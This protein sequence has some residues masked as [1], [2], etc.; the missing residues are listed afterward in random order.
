MSVTRIGSG[1]KGDP[2]RWWWGTVVPGVGAGGDVTG[3]LLGDFY[4]LQTTT[5]PP[6]IGDVFQYTGNEVGTGAQQ[7]TRRGSIQGVPGSVWWQS[8]TDPP[9]G[10]TPALYDWAIVVQTGT[11]A[12]GNIYQCSQVTPSVVWTAHGSMRGPAGPTGA[13]GATG[14]GVPTGGTTGQVLTKTSA[15]DYATAWQAPAGGTGGTGVDLLL[16]GG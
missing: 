9:S 11:A 4:L 6:P 3:A 8:S 12:D 15:T 14:A 1:P 7:W 13:T 5:P 16:M 10:I 2:A